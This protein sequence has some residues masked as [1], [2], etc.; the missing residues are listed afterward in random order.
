MTESA[1]DPGEGSEPGDR[2]RF[3]V[4]VD[5]FDRAVDRAFEP[6]RGNRTADRLF[7]TASH[8]G[9]WSLIWHLLNAAQGLVGERGP[10]RM[11]RNTVVLGFESAFVN[12]GLKRLFNRV[13]PEA[14]EAVLGR[15]RNPTTSSFPSGHASAAFTAAGILTE[16]R[17]PAWRPLAYA[18][19]AVVASSRIHTRMHHA[20]DVLAG[21]AVGITIARAARRWPAP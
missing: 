9:D 19:A 10:E 4:A 5:E 13:R 7:E 20:S 15:I 11:A 8:L 18:T 17:H 1:D 2:S 12:Q 16:G 3:T 14:D 6:L 21:A